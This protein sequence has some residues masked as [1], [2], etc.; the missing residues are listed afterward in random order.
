VRFASAG[1]DGVSPMA[2]TMRMTALNSGLP[3]SPSALYE[4]DAMELKLKPQAGEPGGLRGCLICAIFKQKQQ[5]L[6][7]M[8][9]H[10]CSEFMLIN[11]I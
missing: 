4:I 6:T 3:V 9:R 8:T 11:W 10:L 2:R 7:C 1:R 5:F